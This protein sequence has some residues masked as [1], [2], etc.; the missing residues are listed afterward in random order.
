MLSPVYIAVKAMIDQDTSKVRLQGL[1]GESLLEVFNDLFTSFEE[2]HL[3]RLVTV[4]D[5][6]EID[7]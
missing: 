3:I 2:H 7:S 1:S 6:L 4:V 5:N